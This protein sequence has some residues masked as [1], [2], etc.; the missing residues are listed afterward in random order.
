MNKVLTK[1]FTSKPII[2]VAKV[3]KKG[4]NL[5]QNGDKV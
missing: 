4:L 3:H 1:K 5:V 2:S